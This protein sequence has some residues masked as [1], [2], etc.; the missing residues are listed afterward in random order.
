MQISPF[1]N[2]NCTK[3]S[4]AF[5]AREYAV[6]KTVA[7]GVTTNMKI[8]E[9]F[10]KDRAFLDFMSMS[11]KLEKLTNIKNIT[12]QQLRKWKT[13]INDAIFMSSFNEPQRS[14]LLVTEKNKPCGIMT[15]S[16]VDKE[17]RLDYLATWPVAKGENVKLA[18]TTLLKTLFEDL[19]KSNI[20]SV[21]LT[22][23]NNGPVDLLSYY[24]KMSFKPKSIDSRLGA[25]MFSRRIW[26]EEKS[27]ELGKYIVIDRIS[28]PNDSDLKKVLDIKF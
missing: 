19:L 8:F 17:C 12:K 25:E 13:V 6:A 11:L 24:Q 3:S 18:G 10:D 5:K 21:N 22:T 23:L 27:N 7:N 2:S 14:F 16:C 28:S 1:Y 4:V 26:F 9:V 15:Y 20:S